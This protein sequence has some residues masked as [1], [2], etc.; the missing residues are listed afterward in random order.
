MHSF[1]IYNT[2][3]CHLCEQAMELA[4]PLLDRGDQIDSIDIS[5]SAELMERYGIRIPVIVR[6]DNDAEIDWPFDK[7]QF[8]AFIN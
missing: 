6:R 5:D 1:I 2:V 4:S 3:G 8:L 7:A